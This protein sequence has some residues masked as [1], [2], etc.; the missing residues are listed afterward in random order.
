MGQ[1][2]PKTLRAPED[3]I[4]A[5]I[6]FA[7]AFDRGGPVSDLFKR[8]VQ[9]AREEAARLGSEYVPGFEG[10]SVHPRTPLA[11]SRGHV[12]ARLTPTSETRSRAYPTERPTADQPSVLCG[13]TK[14]LLE[15]ARARHLLLCQ[16]QSARTPKRPP[17]RRPEDA[18]K[19]LD[20]LRAVYQE[21]SPRLSPPLPPSR[22][23]SVRGRASSTLSARPF[24][25]VPFRS[26][27]AASASP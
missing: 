27:I 8:V 14:D 16:A 13:Q 22:R 4:Q 20:P 15:H 10:D 21:R 25:S 17:A 18:S 19:L 7:F 3:R 24:N 9:Y 1:T 12:L 11:E 23:P 6:G 2:I 5:L 26:A